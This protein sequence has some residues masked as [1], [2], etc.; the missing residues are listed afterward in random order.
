MQGYVVS[1]GERWYAVIYEGLDPITGK[2]RRNR[3][4]VDQPW[5]RRHW[6]QAP[7]D[8]RGKTAMARRRVD[9]APATL[10]VLSAWRIWQHPHSFSQAFDR[11]VA[12]A[13]VPR[14]RLHD[15]RHAHGTLLIK[16]GVPAKVV[17]ERL[18]HA[19]PAFTID[20]YQHVLPGMQAEAAKVFE[21]MIKFE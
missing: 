12:R 16:V 19:H 15:V 17:S 3:C 5:T 4:A 14:V 9:L 21:D 8:P 7:R 18:G 11:I 6:L 2:E 20:T 1:K 13:D 10:Q